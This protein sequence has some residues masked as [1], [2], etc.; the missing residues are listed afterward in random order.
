[1]KKLFRLTRRWRENV[2]LRKIWM[3]MKLTIGLFFLAITQMMASE[4][5]SQ[6]AKM[7]LQLN[8]VSVKEVLNRIEEE[9][10]FF[11]LYNSKLVNVDRKVNVDE[12]NQKIN[13]ILNNLFRET[14]V[15]YTIVDRQIVLTNKAD[16]AGFINQSS[17]QQG[18]KVTGKVTDQS[19]T[20]LP[21]VSVV[22]KGTSTGIITDGSG[23]Y[24]LSNIP[25]NA[26]LQFSF[27]GM[28]SQDVNVD[29]KSTVNV[30]LEEQTIGIEEIVAIGYGTQNKKTIT[31]AVSTVSG[32]KLAVANTANFTN[33]LAGRL[34]GLVTVTR[35]GAPGADDATLRIRGN[36]TLNNNNPLIVV[37]GIA[38]RSMG[39]LNANDIESVIIL[40]DAS[41]AIYGAQAANGVIL[42][43]T[44]RGTTGKLKITASY[45]QGFSTPTILPKMADS[46][47]YAT[48]MNEMDSYAGQ[49]GRFTADDLQKFKDGSDPWGHPNTDWFKEVFKPFSL[50]N[51][52]NVNLSGG[53]ESVKYFVS[54]GTR[55]Q[56]AMYR[57]SGSNYSQVDFRSNIDG[58][59]SE[60]INFS[61]DLA[62]RQ[63]NRNLPAITDQPPFRII[64]RGRPSDVSWWPGGLPGPEVESGQNPV[65]M[66]SDIP[67]YNKDTRYIMESNL[68]LNINI[69]WVKG[70][71][72]TGNASIDKNFG[73][74]KTWQ[75]PY[76]LYTWDKLTLDEKGLPKVNGSKSGP[77][78]PMLEMSMDNGQRVT[79]NALINYERRIAEKHKIKLLAGAESSV[80]DNMT[81]SALRKYFV[82]TT[83]DQLFAG[84]DLEKNNNGS[85][86]RTARLN[87]FGRV[88]YD[89]SSKYLAEF[90]WRYD[91]S[92]I[93][94]AD[95]RWG[96]FPGV[97][98][99]WLASE[100]TF[101]KNNL[102][103]F[104]Y[105]KIRGS[106]GQTGNDRISEFQ[107]ISTYGFG[108]TI[109]NGMNG[110]EFVTNQN[111]Q[112]KVLVENSFPNVNVTWE[113]ANQ[114]DIGF[115]AQ[116]F[117][118]KLR[119]E[120]DYFH[121]YR[122]KIL[123][124]RNASIPASTGL[125]LPPEN[126]GEVV[127]QGFELVIGYSDKSRDFGYNVS[128]NGS[129]AK[130]MI[131]FW[132]E[133]P[134]I[135][136]YQRTTG[137][138]M[139]SEL[140]YQS[141]GIFKDV[142][143]VD[144]YPHWVGAR[145]GDVIFKDVNEDGKI[146]AL[147]MVRDYRSNI[148]VF[149]TGLNIDLTY[150]NFYATVFVQGAFGKMRYHNVE[151]GE[152]GNFYMEDAVGRWTTD[153]PDAT[154]P[155]TF[156]YTAEYWKSQLNTYMLRSAD[157][158]RLKN[159]EIGYNFPKSINTKLG[160]DGFRVYVGGLNIITWCP[161]LPSFDPEST[162]QDYPL[163]KVFNL[164]ATLTF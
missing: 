53:T 64:P 161:T 135:P 46:Y 112:N 41:A 145:P 107:Y 118:G 148:P 17:Q 89:Y 56:D 38:N 162:Y 52:A 5:Y 124:I 147:D 44:K 96:F 33:S 36:N 136:E 75:V 8:D 27:V 3:T 26:I 154:K 21:G 95:K 48:M 90:V 129:Y 54:I 143:A 131:K 78:D 29:S 140:Y 61:I 80:G 97:S 104:N 84:S 160:I 153:N 157:Y 30:V 12:K 14:E 125:K 122:S 69:P 94:P 23:N 158:L 93:F 25:A 39:R 62:G 164:G 66:V 120:G 73:V 81:F 11:F 35:S 55:F 163:S 103:F 28:K 2:H 126:I 65:V 79:L 155:R 70:L 20:S 102:A 123:T 130:N 105:F 106:W 37:D 10:E 57:N 113:V 87:Y 116:M 42:I 51:N 47:T 149:T 92:Y 101:W 137:H 13:E 141:I 85:A 159:V 114:S 60:N 6:I 144:A 71:S 111:V 16:Q 72:V 128:V 83:I 138:P 15:V 58:K 115:D 7:T 134:G 76:Y 68:K 32:E 127:N 19:G 110:N 121:N 9:S 18:K 24:L 86:N 63:E 109:G 91:G 108:G 50:E 156:N 117:G 150:K 88:N 77:S 31:G 152:A 4:A 49:K 59:V 99:G 100:E 133:T 139:N 119:L 132:D 22:I 82:S 98:L 1:M 142:A 43:T 34:P 67:G 146:T 40:K 74:E 45:N 151:S